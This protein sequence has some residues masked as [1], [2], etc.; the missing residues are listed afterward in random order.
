MEKA[1]ELN[2]QHCWRMMPHDQDTGGFFV[3]L[4]RK[5]KEIPGP[6]GS[7]NYKVKTTAEKGKDVVKA[8]TSKNNSKDETATAAA[9]KTTVDESKIKILM[10][11]H[12]KTRNTRNV[13]VAKI[14]TL[15][16][17]LMM[18]TENHGTQ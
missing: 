14:Y 12:Y 11:S 18:S 2:L 5:T 9:S 8:A 3:A 1:K 10:L 16:S 4:L 15:S 17:L 7:S 6:S 13:L